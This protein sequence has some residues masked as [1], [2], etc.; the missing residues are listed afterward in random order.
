MQTYAMFLASV[1]LVGTWLVIFPRGSRGRIIWV[2]CGVV[3]LLGIAWFMWQ[4]S[5]PSEPFSD[6]NQAYYPAGH[7]ITHDIS[8]LYDRRVGCEETAVCGYVNIPL[9][10]LTFAPLSMATLGRAQQL[11]ALLSLF[12]VTSAV[13][14]LVVLTAADAW[15]RWAIASLFVLNGP[16][17]YSLREGNLTH[18]ALMLLVF[19]L[20]CVE[21]RREVWAG[22][23]VACVAIIKLP[24]GLLGVVFVLKRQWRIVLGMAMT[25]LA[26]IGMSLFWAGWESHVTWYNE[27]IHPFVSKALA[28]FN[29]QSVDGFLLRLQNESRLYDW[30]PVE[31]DGSIRTVRAVIIGMM[32]LASGVILQRHALE[33]SNDLLFLDLSIVLCLALIIS[34]ISWTHYYVFLLIPF[35][36]YLGGR[37]PVSLGSAWAVSIMLCLVLVSPPVIF[38]DPA[39][40]LLGNSVGK[41]FLSHYFFGALWLWG[42]FCL[43]RWRASKQRHSFISAVIGPFRKAA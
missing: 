2:G 13:H 36:L 16:L 11:F 1:V 20:V 31:V 9:V 30:K 24:L 34:P 35:A 25:L 21:R 26:V 3:I 42:T 43:A 5:D 33:Q 17:F 28:A 32:L 22:A 18:V 39:S 10:A 27:S 40:S 4:V 8:K 14:W 12:C 19:A 41:L 23:L 37:L 7:A 15:K 29:V 6:F 38:L